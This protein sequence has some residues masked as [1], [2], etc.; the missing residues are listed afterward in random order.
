MP[1]HRPLNRLCGSAVHCG[2]EKKAFFFFPISQRMSVPNN[3][4]GTCGLSTPQECDLCHNRHC[5]VIRFIW[6]TKYIFGASFQ[7]KPRGEPS[8]NLSGVHQTAATE[9]PANFNPWQ[10][11]KCTKL[12]CYEIY[13]NITKTKKKHL[14]NKTK[15]LEN[16]WFVVRKETQAT[17]LTQCLTLWSI[18]HIGIDILGEKKINSQHDT[19]LQFKSNYAHSD[20]MAGCILKLLDLVGFILLSRKLCTH[21]WTVWFLKWNFSCVINPIRLMVVTSCSRKL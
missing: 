17:L 13:H 6:A 7:V 5:R 14:S 16:S 19:G 15:V 4:S 9:L 2:M 1:K 8:T 11:T 3:D 12:C 21:S 18:H 10:F 20:F